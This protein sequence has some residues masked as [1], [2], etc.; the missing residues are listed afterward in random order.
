MMRPETQIDKG[1]K[2][3][4][5]I[6]DFLP[7]YEA[8]NG[9]PQYRFPSWKAEVDV[10]T[11]RKKTVNMRGGFCHAVS[12]TAGSWDESTPGWPVKEEDHE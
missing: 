10:F 9:L 5:V 8:V 7:R 3:D 2:P 12:K 6:G 1:Q 4:Y 11:T